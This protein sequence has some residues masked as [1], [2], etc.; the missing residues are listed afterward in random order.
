MQEW[1]NTSD[2]DSN[3]VTG[4]LPA[5]SIKEYTAMDLWDEA[6]SKAGKILF[7]MQ[8]LW[9]SVDWLRQK[10]RIENMCYHL[11]KEHKNHFPDTE[12]NRQWF[13]KWIKEFEDETENMC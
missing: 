8:F 12:E 13:R 3:S 1:E 9:P 7:Y 6:W 10:R 2:I 5:M 4:D 11:A